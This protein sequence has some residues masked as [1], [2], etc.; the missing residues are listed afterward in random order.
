LHRLLPLQIAFAL[1]E[2]S[3][4]IKPMWQARAK[5]GKIPYKGLLAQAKSRRQPDL[6][7]EK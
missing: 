3:G 6:R 2:M 1:S 7:G 4:W 5:S